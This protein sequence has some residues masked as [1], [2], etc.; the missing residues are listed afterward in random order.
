MDHPE[1]PVATRPDRFARR[2]EIVLA[3][4][5]LDRRRL[6]RWIVA[7]TGLSAAWI[8]DDGD[9][10]AVD[11]AVGVLAQAALDRLG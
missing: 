5:G 6:L 1:P 7:W 8:L 4:S 9:D 2:L 11:L 3:R 10:P